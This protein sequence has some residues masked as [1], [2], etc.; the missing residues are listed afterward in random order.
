MTVPL[1]ESRLVPSNSEFTQQDGW[2]ERTVR[3]KRELAITFVFCR[4]RHLH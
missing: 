2:K 3:D 1:S 4:D